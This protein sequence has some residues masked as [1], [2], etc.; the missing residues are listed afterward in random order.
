MHEQAAARRGREQ[1]ESS[2]HA[3]VLG[4][5]LQQQPG[6]EVPG[7]RT[8]CADVE[9]DDEREAASAGPGDREIE[10]HAG[11][12]VDTQV[13]V[14]GVGLDIHRCRPIM[15]K[16][17]QRACAPCRALCTREVHGQARPAP[18]GQRMRSLY[19]FSSLSR[20]VAM[21]AAA[22]PSEVS[23]ALG[24]SAAWP[25]RFGGRRV[26]DRSAATG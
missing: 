12:A 5:L 17:S 25:L 11:D 15:P 7:D 14:I 26:A 10:Q 6:A 22:Q 8:E 16:G 9:I 18:R 23:A 24:R 19:S 1:P 13:P 3:G 2:R 21:S 20:L 4:V